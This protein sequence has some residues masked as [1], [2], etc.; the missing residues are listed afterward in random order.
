VAAGGAA[1]AD[2]HCQDIG[3]GTLCITVDHVG[4]EGE[5]LNRISMWYQKH[6]GDPVTIRFFYQPRTFPDDVRSSWHTVAAGEV[7]S[8]QDLRDAD[9]YA[10]GMEV[11]GGPE[12]YLDKYP[13]C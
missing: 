12:F 1:A 3:N 5:Q 2:S 8:W 9:C 7:T 13:I 11:Q 6:L 10:A 4:G